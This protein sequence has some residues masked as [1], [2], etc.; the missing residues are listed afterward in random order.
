MKEVQKWQKWLT[1][2]DERKIH[3]SKVIF[4]ISLLTKQIPHKHKHE[5]ISFPG[6]L[7]ETAKEGTDAGP[8]FL[9]SKAKEHAKTWN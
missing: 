1:K 3:P 5:Q 4:P 2:H 6:G 9:L 7:R 8:T